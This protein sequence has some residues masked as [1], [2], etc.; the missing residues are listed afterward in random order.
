MSSITPARDPISEPVA[1]V[2]EVFGAHPAS[3]CFPEVDHATLEGLAGELRQA[4]AEVE[5]SERALQ[6]ARQLLDERRDALRARAERG[7]AY[8]RIYAEDD[9]ALRERLEAIDLAATAQPAKRAQ[10]RHP[11]RRSRRTNPA[12]AD[13]SVKELPFSPASPAA[14]HAGAA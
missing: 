10:K 3:L 8:A 12:V 4:A 13:E 6:Q 11:A 14:V 5:R 7:L 2:I 1:A 9:D